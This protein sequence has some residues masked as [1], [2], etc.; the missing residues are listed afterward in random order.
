MS[1]V[2]NTFEQMIESKYLKK[3]DCMPDRLLTIR[4]F[5]QEN[6]AQQGEPPEHKWALYFEE[7][8][9]PLL[10]NSTN[11]QLL[12]LHL[13]VPGPAH[14]IGRKVVL[15]NDPT[16]SFGGK[17]TGGIRLRAPR[18]KRSVEEVNRELAAQGVDDQDVPF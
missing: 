17:L 12:K 6:V 10:L 13:G 8:A 18:T 1:Q 2:P 16:V 4:D 7:E 15:F 11:I 9:K 5:Q 14:A 3:E